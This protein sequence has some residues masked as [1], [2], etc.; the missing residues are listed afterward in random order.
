MRLKCLAA[1][2]GL[3]GWTALAAAGP[4]VVADTA[5]PRYAIDIE[6]FATCDGDRVAMPDEEV[7]ADNRMTADPGPSDPAESLELNASAHGVVQPSS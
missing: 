5:C 7:M 3:G 2:L 4:A 6:A 1:A